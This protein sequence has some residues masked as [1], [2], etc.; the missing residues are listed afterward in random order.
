MSRRDARALASGVRVVS[1]LA[2]C[3]V[4]CL[5]A[6]PRQSA[7]MEQA[8]GTMTASE[9][10]VDALELGQWAQGRI[11]RAADSIATSD[12]PDVRRRALLWKINA[13]PMIQE[14]TL[15]PDPLGAVADLRAFALQMR[16][17]FATGPGRDLFGPAQSLAIHTADTI[18]EAAYA[19]AARGLPG[20]SVPTR[21]ARRVGTWVE[22]HPITG[23]DFDRVSLATEWPDIRA[24]TVGGLV[25]TVGSA[26]ETLDRV[27][28]RLGF[29]NRYLMKQV[30][31]NV[32][33][34]GATTIDRLQRLDLDTLTSLASSGSTALD[35]I[36]GLAAGTPSLAE[37]ER[38]ALLSGVGDERRAI[39]AA[40]DGERIALSAAI[41]T[42]RV[43]T[44]RDVR[45]ERIETTTAVDDIVQRSID[46][47]F[48]RGVELL[49]V[50]AVLGAC[51]L[52]AAR[53][54]W[55]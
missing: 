33:L 40:L 26:S 52:V 50:A 19:V 14:A 10:R 53:W 2:L 42:Q 31:W 37:R 41:D 25:Q 12:D 5:H 35:R 34:M 29:L 13:L 46:H 23:L 39:M 9:L 36:G 7:L 54:A 4:A 43:A 22:K 30:R 38:I 18:A 15:Q 28:D 21:A 8:G 20:D 55:R 6:R 51:G 45:I 16:E 17:F 49:I 32:E 1:L 47:A 48:W 11:E 44:L 3:T 27:S 24:Q